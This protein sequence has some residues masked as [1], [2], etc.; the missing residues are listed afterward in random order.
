MP[1][2]VAV[3]TYQEMRFR[4]AERVD[5]RPPSTSAVPIF[6]PANA[7]TLQSGAVAVSEDGRKWIGLSGWLD[8]A[9]AVLLCRRTSLTIMVPAK[10]PADVGLLPPAAEPTAR[11]EWKEGADAKTETLHVMLDLAQRRLTLALPFDDTPDGRNKFGQL[12][13]A[14]STAAAE[15]QAILTCQHGY[16]TRVPAPQTTPTGDRVGD[17]VIRDHR[18]QD[19]IVRQPRLDR[20]WVVRDHRTV[21][22]QNVEVGGAQAMALDREAVLTSR[23]FRTTTVFVRQ[24]AEPTLEPG[25]LASEAHLPLFRTRSDVQAFP[26]LPR[27]GQSGWG[28]VPGREGKAGLHYRDSPE[29][30]SFFYLPTAFKLGYGADESSTRPPMRAEIY[31]DDAGQHR[32]RATL[33][34]LPFID[35]PDREALRLHV[36]SAVLQDTIPFVRLSPA[37]GLTATFLADFS[38]GDGTATLPANIKFTPLEVAPDKWLRLQF[39]MEAGAY[40]VFCELLRKGIRGR[41]EL[42]AEGIQNSVPVLLDLSE[43]VSDAVR[44]TA[45]AAD[46]LDLSVENGINLPATLSSLRAV[47]LDT[48][49]VAGLIFDAEEQELLATGGQRLDGGGK[50]TGRIAPQRIAGWDERVLSLGPVR[51]DGGAPQDWLDRVNRDPSLTP[52]PLRVLV[53]LSIPAFAAP[54]VELVQLRLMRDGEQAARQEHRLMPGSAALNLAVDLTLAEL[55]SG[56]S[57]GLFLEYETLQK[58]GRLSPRQRQ[59]IRPSQREMVLITL[60]DKDDLI[61]TVD[62]VTADRSARDEVDRG[63]LLTRVQELSQA[64][65]ARWQIYARKKEVP[66]TPDSTTT[67]PTTPQGPEMRILCDLIEPALTAGTVK[68]VIV[69]LQPTAA[70]AASSTIVLEP[71]QSASRGWRPSSGTV[72]P[73]AYSVTYILPDGAS[74]KVQGVEDGSSLLIDWPLP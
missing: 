46:V 63:Q 72:P 26:D 43:V 47:L 66:T 35:E 10:G 41:V 59:A 57:T 20:P 1:A 33:V 2:P 56:A 40:P 34:A 22:P 17:V 49:P 36:R 30:D 42:Q 65:G 7:A 52:Q 29:A 13:S 3:G 60:V 70:G 9:A 27:A 14:L 55:S 51:V 25:T 62:S 54:D 61:Y 32:V 71:G 68:K 67:T 69:V 74:R 11:I 23:N 5:R 48:G 53:S 19:R 44:V 6:A 31:L 39:D 15:C 4:M 16:T 38:A 21:R 18:N 45:G 73:F 37:S 58:D 50:W 28:Q 8:A 24:A 12:V 64:P